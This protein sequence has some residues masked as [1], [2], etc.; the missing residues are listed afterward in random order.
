MSFPSEQQHF[1][2]VKALLAAVDARPYDYDE[3]V[4]PTKDAYSL[5]SV[6]DR[7]GG[8]LR[9][10]GQVGTRGVRIS[11]R[12]VGI[13]ADNVREMRRRGDGALREQSVTV[14]GRASTPIQ[15]ETAESVSQDGDV[16]V[17]KSWWS[18][19]TTYTYVV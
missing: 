10:S 6:A 1:D 14:A 11:V 7:F 3:K 19:L 16:P 17:T 12:Y 18:A 9:N 2:A 4:P 13:S 5:L 8:V 15:F